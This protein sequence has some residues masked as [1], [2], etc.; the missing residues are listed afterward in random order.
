MIGKM[1]VYTRTHQNIQFIQKG[2]AEV[3]KVLSIRNSLIQLMSTIL[4]YQSPSKTDILLQMDLVQMHS[5]LS[6]LC[7]QRDMNINLNCHCHDLQAIGLR[8]IKR[9]SV[10]SVLMQV[11]NGFIFFEIFL[12]GLFVQIL[13][14]QA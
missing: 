12:Q 8:C 9:Y 7:K 13:F 11:F 5:F 3:V 2:V 4:A 10:T 6:E 1:C 14:M